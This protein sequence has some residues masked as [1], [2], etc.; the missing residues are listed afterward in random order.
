[1]KESKLVKSILA[2]IIVVALGIPAIASA[3]S[4]SDLEGVSVKVSYADLNLAK[5]EAAEIL[6]RRLQH[7]SEQACGVTSLRNSGSVQRVRDS[8]L[9]YRETL[10]AAVE[11]VDNNLLSQIHSS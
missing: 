9:C 5:L 2:T 7:A 3:D 10:T 4:K 8:K 6:Y 11:R 1:M